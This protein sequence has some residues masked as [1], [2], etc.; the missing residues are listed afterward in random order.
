MEGSQRLIGQ[1]TLS[2]LMI[3]ESSLPE[4]HLRLRINSNDTYSKQFHPKN[5]CYSFSIEFDQPAAEALQYRIN[6]RNRYQIISVT[7]PIRST[8]GM[9]HSPDDIVKLTAPVVKTF[10]STTSRSSSSVNNDNNGMGD[11][12]SSFGLLSHQAFHSLHEDLAS[13]HVS[14]WCDLLT[15]QPNNS[16]Y[17]RVYTKKL[18]P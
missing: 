1:S 8:L 11:F 14:I 9:L 7:T 16:I 4:D 17:D 15:E 10:S 6:H 2:T 18:P 3:D 5:N 13:L 12:K